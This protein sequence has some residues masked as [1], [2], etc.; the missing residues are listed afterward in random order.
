M[1]K[2]RLLAIALLLAGILV[3][4]FIFSS[5]QPEQ[6]EQQNT[7][8]PFKFGLDLSGGTHLVYRADVSGV[9]PEEV[10][11][12]MSALRDVIERRINLFGVAEPNVQIERTSGIISDAQD[13]R[14][15][16]ELPGVTNIDQATAMIG[17]TPL[18]EFRLERPEGPEKE[19][20]KNSI[21]AFQEALQQGEEISEADLPNVDELFITTELTGRFLQKATLGFDQTT[22]APRILLDFDKEG[23][24]LFAE[25]TGEN[26]GKILAIYLDGAPISQ[27]VIQQE[28]RGGSAEITGVFTPEEAKQL[29]GRLNSGALPVPIE[30]LSSQTIGSTLGQE[31]KTQGVK[32]GI[33]GLIA[34][35]IFM[36]FWY[37]LPGLIA[38]IA[39]GIYIALML[40]IFKLVPV[41]ITAAG[42]A[43]FILSIGMAVD[44]NVLIFERTKEELK[45]GTAIRDAITEGF[46]RAW[47]A[48]RDSNISSIITAIILFWFGTSLI[49]GFALVFGI[50]V[51]ISM[52]TAISV[53]RTL[54][55]AI[56]S[57]NTPQG[58]TKFL[59]GADA[60]S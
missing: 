59:F 16:V 53:T 37:R 56:S 21:Q 5:E 50:G 48:I 24:E 45:K 40:A 18:L 10:R 38:I 32:A 23:G 55:L 31:A 22:G 17:Q 12:A 46:S 30:L 3:G 6:S 14:L 39:L 7:N 13:E 15:I 34:V 42:I 4:Y 25:I 35:A 60:K 27:P 1:L 54:L 33:V 9:A 8:F 28:I 47:L 2:I 19:N 52:I 51:L 43:G 41:T 49:K 20:I 26:V 58:I 57:E 29:V 44:A 11:D 36:L